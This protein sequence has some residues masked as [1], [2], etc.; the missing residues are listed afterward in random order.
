MA[1]RP[2]VANLVTPLSEQLFMCPD[3]DCHHDRC[4][5]PADYLTAE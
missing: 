5:L 2:R 1:V 3:C 4:L